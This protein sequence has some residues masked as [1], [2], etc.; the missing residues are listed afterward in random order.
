M[1]YIELKKRE[2]DFT[3]YPLCLTNGENNVQ[4]TITSSRSGTT[5]DYVCIEAVKPEDAT[6]N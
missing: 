2:L 4:D 5:S 6:S 3:R 1:F